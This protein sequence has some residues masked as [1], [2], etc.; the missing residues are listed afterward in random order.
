M[1]RI[2]LLEDDA[3]LALGLEFSLKEEGYMMLHMLV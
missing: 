1:G 3:S 2:L